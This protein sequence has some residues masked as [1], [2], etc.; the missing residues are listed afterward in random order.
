[1]SKVVALDDAVRRHIPDGASVVMG[2]G[3]EALIPFACGYEIIRQKKENLTLIAPISDMLFDILIGAG[4]VERIIAAWMGNVSAGSGHNF[5]RAVE[6]GVPRAVEVIDHTN[7]TLALAL[8]AAALGVP[9]LPARTA[10]GSDLLEANAHL[11]RLRC[12]F[13]NDELVAVEALVPDVAVLAVQRCDTEGNAHVTGNLGVVGDAARAARTTVVFTEEIVDPGVIR[14]DPN[15]TLVPGFLVSAVVHAP[16]GCKP[17]PVLGYY[18]RDHAFFHAYH[19][20]SR[21]REGFLGWLDEAT[22]G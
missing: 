7:L 2:A 11:E 9:Y 6:H 12:P 8:H 10:L 19:E 15:R 1:M 20:R 3:L 16:G 17:S 4:V 21:S 18:E 14:D 5:R 22:A 13:T